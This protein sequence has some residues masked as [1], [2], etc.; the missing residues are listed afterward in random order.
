MRNL[1]GDRWYTRCTTNTLGCETHAIFE[2]TYSKHL[3]CPLIN[4][5]RTL[6]S[7]AGQL[8]WDSLHTSQQISIILDKLP[9]SL[10]NKLHK[11]WT[12]TTLDK[13]LTIH[14][15]PRSTSVHMT[16]HKERSHPPRK[17]KKTNTILFLPVVQCV[18]L[19]L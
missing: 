18:F 2:Y 9:L 10:P 8:S 6:L 1:Y 19:P 11:T 13:N 16:T 17:E 15:F 12:E 7:K 4:K 14:L 5:L 3:V